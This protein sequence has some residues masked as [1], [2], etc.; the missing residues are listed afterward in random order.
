MIGGEF[1]ELPKTYGEDHNVGPN[2]WEHNI[3]I[4]MYKNFGGKY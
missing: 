3:D 4:R 2:D 1:S